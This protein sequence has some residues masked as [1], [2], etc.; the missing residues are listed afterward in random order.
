MEKFLIR[1]FFVISPAF[2]VGGLSYVFV[3]D[4]VLSGFL[5]VFYIGI[6]ILVTSNKSNRG[7]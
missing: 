4:L 6:G 2:I 3:R 1:S 7:E 5:F